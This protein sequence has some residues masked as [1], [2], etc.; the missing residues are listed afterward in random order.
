MRRR[1][2]LKESRLVQMAV[3]AS[4]LAIP[5]SAAALGD[6]PPAGS[7]SV[8]PAHE[9]ARPTTIRLRRHQFNVAGDRALHLSGRLLPGEAGRRVRLEALQSGRWRTLTTALTGPQ[10]EFDLRYVPHSPGRERLRVGISRD[11]ARPGLW[12]AAGTLTSYRQSVASWYE[13]GGETAC[14]FH[15][16]YGVA[17]LTLPCG[18]KV[19][20]MNG[21]RNVTAVVDDRGPYVDGRQWDL[22]QNT[23]GALGFAGVGTVWSSE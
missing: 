8:E 12:K 20:F 17:N 23:A 9:A 19:S 5:A 1:P 22:N 16:Y 18:T 2:A 14:G 4:M 3:G 10:G 15:A 7:G 11:E 6:P 13:D 21:G